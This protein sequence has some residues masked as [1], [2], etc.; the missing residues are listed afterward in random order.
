MFHQANNDT[1]QTLIWA[2]S[3]S[4]VSD[5]STNATIMGHI[6]MGSYSVNLQNNTGSLNPVDM[7]ASL[8]SP[9]S[10]DTVSNMATATSTSANSPSQ[11]GSATSLKAV[12]KNVLLGGALSI[13]AFVLFF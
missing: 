6:A 13:T 1:T 11:T 2:F 10:S 8:V 9:S 3:N 4:T 12:G 7:K 5:S